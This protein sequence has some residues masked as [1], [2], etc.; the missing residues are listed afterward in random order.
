[1]SYCDE[2]GKLVFHASGPVCEQTTGLIPWYRVPERKTS[3]L[4]IIFADEAHFADTAFPGI[5]PLPTQDS[6]SALTLTAIPETISV[7]YCD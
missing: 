2:N 6:L 1:M 4:N 5:Y 7:T 3:N